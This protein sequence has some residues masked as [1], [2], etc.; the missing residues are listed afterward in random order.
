MF[1]M[2]CGKWNAH[3]GYANPLGKT[4]ILVRCSGVVGPGPTAEGCLD[5]DVDKAAE[6]IMAGLSGDG[7]GAR[8]ELQT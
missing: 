5:T 2:P 4:E 8:K 6:E 3:F 1:R 7:G